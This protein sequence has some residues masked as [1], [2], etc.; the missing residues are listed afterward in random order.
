MGEHLADHVEESDYDRRM[1]ERYREGKSDGFVPSFQKGVS[2]GTYSLFEKI[3]NLLEQ[4]K[5]GDE[6]LNDELYAD[7]S[8]FIISKNWTS[9]PPMKKS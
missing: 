3:R 9:P 1:I 8:F 4:G 6:I 2:E 7:F 5:T